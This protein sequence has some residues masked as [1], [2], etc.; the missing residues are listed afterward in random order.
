MDYHLKII[1]YTDTLIKTQHFHLLTQKIPHFIYPIIISFVQ[2]QILLAQRMPCTTGQIVVL[3]TANTKWN[4]QDKVI[5][6]SYLTGTW[7]V[8]PLLNCIYSWLKLVGFVN[9][10][11]SIK[12]LPA[13]YPLYLN[14]NIQFAL[15][16]MEINFR[17][18]GWS[19]TTHVNN[20]FHKQRLSYKPLYRSIQPELTCKTEVLWWVTCIQWWDVKLGPFSLITTMIIMSHG[21]HG[22][23]NHQQ[24]FNSLLKQTA[25]QPSNLCITGLFWAESIGNPLPPHKRPVML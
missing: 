3:K 15:I 23:S 20:I 13:A 14:Q 8:K 25:K 9:E 16:R 1:E 4:L 21:C 24:L 2:E 19:I 17:C 22:I 11:V 10:C 6:L 7:N 12:W 5:K 18:H